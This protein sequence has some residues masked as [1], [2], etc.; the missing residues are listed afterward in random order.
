MS[1]EDKHPMHRTWVM[2]GAASLAYKAGKYEEA[3]KTVALCRTLDPDDYTS[4]KLD[5]LEE[6]TAKPL[7]SVR[8]TARSGSPGCSPPPMPMKRKL[9]SGTWKTNSFMP[10]SSRRS[11]LKMW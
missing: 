8:K 7:P 10:S 2:N 9:K 3:K 11:C 6:L 5:E 4:S 1:P